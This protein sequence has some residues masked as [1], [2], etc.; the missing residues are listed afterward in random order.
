MNQ[1]HSTT[2]TNCNGHC[3]RCSPNTPP[4][5][6]GFHSLQNQSQVHM[7]A[8][9]FMLMWQYHIKG[10]IKI[11]GT[12]TW[13]QFINI[14]SVHPYKR[15]SSLLCFIAFKYSKIHVLVNSRCSKAWHWE[16]YITQTMVPVYYECMCIES[17]HYLEWFVV[18]FPNIV[19]LYN[20]A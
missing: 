20:S 14:S 7:H 18:C 2:S 11:P 13:R 12:S 8:R 5:L 1:Q 3:Y 17:P 16:D 6:N 4:S 15:Q 10:N 9:D 19:K